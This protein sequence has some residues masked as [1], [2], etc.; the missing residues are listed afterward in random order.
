[1]AAGARKF[2]D[3]KSAKDDATA[4]GDELLTFKGPKLLYKDAKVDIRLDAEAGRKKITE[5][6]DAIAKRAKPD[7]VL[8]VFFAGHGDLL[9]PKDGPQPKGGRAVLAG[10]GTFLFC[11]PDYTPA[12][13]AAPAI[14]VEGLFA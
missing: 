3:L 7:D 1:N 13:P 8:V 12:D 2:G 14:S 10:E 9:M 11:C 5:N 6:L 4:L